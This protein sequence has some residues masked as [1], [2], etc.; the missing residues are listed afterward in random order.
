MA[1]PSQVKNVVVVGATG[2]VVKSL[3]EANKF[4]ITPASRNPPS[5]E[6]SSSVIV[7]TGDYTSPSFLGN[8]RW[9][10]CRG[11]HPALQCSPGASK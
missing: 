11:L 8:L 5:T 10:R 6:F 7:K 1:T 3:L 2:T 4:K 9:S